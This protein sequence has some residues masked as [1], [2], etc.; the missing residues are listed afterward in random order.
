[1]PGLVWL[2]LIPIFNLYWMFV[3]VARI[4][5][6]I[7]KEN[8][9]LMDDS[10]LGV[11]DPDAAG[12][13]GKRPT[14]RIGMAYCVQYVLLYFVLIIFF[15]LFGGGGDARDFAIISLILSLS[16]ITCWI[17][18][19]VKLAGEKRKLQYLQA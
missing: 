1:R 18:Y 4:A 2:Q 6:S 15:N 8:M 7:Y 14:Y 13:L 5:D 16:V 19:W 12:S 17:I 10:I 9:S 11:P 3:V